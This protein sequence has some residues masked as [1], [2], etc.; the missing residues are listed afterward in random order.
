MKLDEVGSKSEDAHASKRTRTEQVATDDDS[1]TRE[2]SA[3]SLADD[4]APTTPIDLTKE[5]SDPTPAV[6]ADGQN[7]DTV[8]GDGEHLDHPENWA[9]GDDPATDKQK[10]FIKV[11]EKQKGATGG[12]VDHLG[13]SEASAKIDE[14]KQM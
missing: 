4:P 6:A 14:L 1:A 9:T 11:L 2:A 7:G 8:P 10:G 12:D 13:K 3:N 5:P